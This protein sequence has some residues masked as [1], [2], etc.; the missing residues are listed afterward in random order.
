MGKKRLNALSLVC[1]HRDI[2]LDCDKIIDFYA[3]KYARRMLLINPLKG[4][5][6][7]DFQPGLKFQL[8]KPS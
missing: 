3:S 7:G 2:F 6:Y 8:V 1:T 4:R 5:L